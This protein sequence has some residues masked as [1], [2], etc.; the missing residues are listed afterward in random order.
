VM[1]PAE[2]ARMLKLAIPHAE[3]QIL[4][5]MGHGY[6][7]EAQEIADE[8]VIDFVRRHGRAVERSAS[9]AR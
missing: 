2:N 6:N 5:G 1:I 9:A 8:L 3:L 4:E 7:L